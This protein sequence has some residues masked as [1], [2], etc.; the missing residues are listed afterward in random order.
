M[1]ILSFIVAEGAF[2]PYYSGDSSMSRFVW[3]WHKTFFLIPQ[4]A[5]DAAPYQWINFVD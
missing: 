3:G 4:R 5:S 1:V 2:R